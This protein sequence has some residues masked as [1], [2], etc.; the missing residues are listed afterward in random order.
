MLLAWAE[1]VAGGFDIVIEDAP[2]AIADADV[3]VATTAMNAAVEA[4]A[5]RRL[6]WYQWT[7]KRWSKRPKESG[8]KNPYYPDCY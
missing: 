7:Y 2:A 1:P 4:V 3:Q 6:E 5:R 8:E